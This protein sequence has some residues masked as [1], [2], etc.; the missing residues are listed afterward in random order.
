MVMF[1]LY[2]FA[3]EITNKVLTYKIKMIMTTIEKLTA[4]VND[5][6]LFIRKLYAYLTYVTL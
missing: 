2:T 1:F 6:K 5:K 4:I 3:S